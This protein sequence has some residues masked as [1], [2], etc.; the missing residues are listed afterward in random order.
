MYPCHYVTINSTISECDHK[1]ETRNADP[2]IGTERSIQTRQML[3]VE[4][5]GSRFGPLRVSWSGFW[6]GLEQKRPVFAVQTRTTG[7]LPGP[8]ANT[9]AGSSADSRDDATAA[10]NTTR[11]NR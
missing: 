9:T 7:R 11:H 6:T 1:C 4:G 5:Y 10:W 3:C 8:V 2:E